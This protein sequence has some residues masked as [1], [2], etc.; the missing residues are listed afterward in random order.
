MYSKFE[1]YWFMFWRFSFQEILLNNCQ[2][3]LYKKLINVK[4]PITVVSSVVGN[5][6]FVHFYLRYISQKSHLM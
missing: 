6:L 4:N 1:T 3:Y 5:V 2:I